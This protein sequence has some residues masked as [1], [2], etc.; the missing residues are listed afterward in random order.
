M[1]LCMYT[2]HLTEHVLACLRLGVN[3]AEHHLHDISIGVFISPSIR[4]LFL[5]TYCKVWP[6]IC[7]EANEEL[8]VAIRAGRSPKLA[9]FHLEYT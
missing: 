5:V 9:L 3:V 8:I 4:Y 2:R 1:N 6:P 7:Q